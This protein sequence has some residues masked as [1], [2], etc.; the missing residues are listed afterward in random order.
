L[1]NPCKKCINPA[2][3]AR[4]PTHHDESYCIIGANQYF[5]S[6]Q[7]VYLMPLRSASAFPASPD[8]EAL[9]SNYQECRAALVSANRS[10]GALNAEKIRQ[11]V[12]VL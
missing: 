12:E 10:P 9:E 6:Q 4:R 3:K 7:V 8:T 11:W 1:R 2:A 5:C